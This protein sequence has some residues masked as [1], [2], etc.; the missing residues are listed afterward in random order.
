M[1]DK[2]DSSINQSRRHFFVNAGGTVGAVALISVLPSTVQAAD[3]PHVTATD[4][5][6]T[7]LGYNPD[8]T[9]VTNSKHTAGAEC[10]NCNLYQGGTAAFGPC[11]FFPGKSVSATGW[12]TSYIKKA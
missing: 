6:A 12:C 5:M 3:L 7:T 9:K 11:P 2:I 10:S 1:S 4:P 8:S